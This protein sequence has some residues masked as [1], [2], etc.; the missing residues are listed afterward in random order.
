MGLA[1]A[2]AL[3]FQMAA[4]P[5]VSAKELKVLSEKTVTGLGHVESV[6]YDADGKVFYTS[7]FGPALKPPLKGRQGQDHQSLAGRKNP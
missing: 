6:G 5:A 1:L 7:D 3:A 2:G 4:A